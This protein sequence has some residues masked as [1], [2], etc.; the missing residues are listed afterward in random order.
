[1]MSEGCAVGCVL[2]SF[3]VALVYFFASP[4]MFLTQQDSSF[5]IEKLGVSRAAR[6]LFCD[7]VCQQSSFFFPVMVSSGAHEMAYCGGERCDAGMYLSDDLPCL[8]CDPDMLEAVWHGMFSS[9]KLPSN[10]F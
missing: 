3:V 10:R 5:R 8:H 1:M 4:L 7:F 2:T 6:N 9:P